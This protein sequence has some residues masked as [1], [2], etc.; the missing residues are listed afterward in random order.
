[1]SLLKLIETKVI[2]S[3]QDHQHST[4]KAKLSPAM[5]IKEKALFF[6]K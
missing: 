3:I 2:L 1:M 5:L 4:C 6:A